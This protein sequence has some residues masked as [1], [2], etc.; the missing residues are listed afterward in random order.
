MAA[1]TAALALA[2]LGGCG[3]SSQTA[4]ANATSARVS[5]SAAAA[6]AAPRVVPIVTGT[7]PHD[8]RAFTEGLL[9]HGGVFY[10]STGL[11]GSSDVRRVR[12]SDGRVLARRALPRR[13]FGE[14]LAMA[15]G[16]L[17]QLTWK[18]R[19]ALVWSPRGLGRA[20]GFRYAG[21]GWGLAR[22]GRRLV[23]SDGTATL[24]VL[25]PATFRVVRRVRVTDGGR[26]VARLNEL[27]VVGGR[28][29]ANV[30]Q[31]DDIV[32]ID[33]AT[34]RVRLRVD[35]SG[36]RGLLPPGG[37]PEV[38]NGIAWDPASQAVYVTGKWWPLMFRLRLPDGA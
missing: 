9:L 5:P 6:A 20:G 15:R 31:S 19:T 29:W 25:D 3:G 18:E 1:G 8:P 4:T 17:V 28:I 30:W 11:Y 2:A 38:L 10:E 37:R 16:R 23:M 24:R 13:M 22:M 12:P 35:A 33:P 34:G 32:V 14:G 26:P 27:E 7:L 21:Q 36:L